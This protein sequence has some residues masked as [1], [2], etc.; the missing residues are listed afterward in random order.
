MRLLCQLSYVSMWYRI[1][2]SNQCLL[3]Q[4]QVRCRY[5][6]PVCGGQGWI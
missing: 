1:L 3:V 2:E 4:S 6:N 5:A